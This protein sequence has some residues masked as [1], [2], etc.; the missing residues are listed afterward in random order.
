MCKLH[1]GRKKDVLMDVL[2]VDIR[3]T[4]IEYFG[5]WRCEWMKEGE[6]KREREREGEREKERL[7]HRICKHM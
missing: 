3:C 6:R 2:P 5:C 4:V 7:L 1:Q